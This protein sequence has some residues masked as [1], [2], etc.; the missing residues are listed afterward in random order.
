MYNRLSDMMLILFICDYRWWKSLS[1]R[2][3]WQAV[4]QDVEKWQ[5]AQIKE[6]EERERKAEEEAAAAHK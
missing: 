3:S 5:E 2:P 1:E 4:Q 6:Q